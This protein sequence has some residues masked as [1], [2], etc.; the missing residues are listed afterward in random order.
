MHGY[1][2]IV[3]C[4]VLVEVL[5]N[6]KG[7]LSVRAA[8]RPISTKRRIAFQ[9]YAV[10]LAQFFTPIIARLQQEAPDIDIHFIILPHPHFS[11]GSLRELRAFAR[12]VLKVPESNIHFFW[13]V[14]WE[15][16]DLLVCT[17]VYAKFPLRSTRKVLLKHGAG[18]ASRILKWHPFRKTIFDFDLV[19][20][21]GEADYELLS[22][23]CAPKFVADRVIAA[24]FP[25]LDRLQTCAETREDYLGRVGLAP[26]QKVALVA[27]SW[28]GLQAIESRQPGYLDEIIT[29]LRDLDWQVILKLHACSFNKAMAQGED[30]AERLY[31]YRRQS[32]RIDNHIDDVPALRHADLL[33]TDISSR[34][35]DFMLL[36]KPT[37]TV[38]PDDLFTDRLDRE[39]IKLLREGAFSASSPAEI[40]SMITRVLNGS[41]PLRSERQRLAHRFFANPGH[42]TEV[43]VGHL[44]HQVNGDI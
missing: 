2:L 5:L 44:L 10:H 25:Y 28:R 29:V 13:Q 36:G 14:L 34:A 16:Y 11:L 1:Q 27:P 43:L 41:D 12:D 22:D 33:I 18:I 42:A 35:F 15:K 7:L 3:G 6:L 32:I 24:G 30:W 39:R 38:F 23:A 19:L 26:N 21:N 4:R 17:D 20:V 8:L 37:I 31:R 40:K 9:A